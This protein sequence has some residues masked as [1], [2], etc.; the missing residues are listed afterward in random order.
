MFWCTN[1]SSFVGQIELLLMT[2]NDTMH[3][4][5]SKMGINPCTESSDIA[6][7]EKTLSNSRNEN[8]KKRFQ[9]S[10][11]SACHVYECGPCVYIV[12]AVSIWA[13][14]ACYS[15]W[16]QLQ[17]QS[18]AHKCWT[19]SEP[20]QCT[21]TSTANVY[22]CF[23]S[24][25]ILLSIQ[26]HT[27]QTDRDEYRVPCAVHRPSFRF[28]SSRFVGEQLKQSWC[29]RRAVDGRILVCIECFSYIGIWVCIVRSIL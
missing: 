14:I 25:L 17:V 16:L 23:R 20:L 22:R 15:L 6:R 10:A 27:A 12:Y 24:C 7:I 26:F 21:S 9:L 29:S 3:S 13:S 8:E 1:R 2:C 18:G 4:H 19:T 28:R 5:T 11:Q